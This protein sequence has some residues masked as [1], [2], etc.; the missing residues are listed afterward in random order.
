MASENAFI[1][2]NMVP[3]KLAVLNT[4]TTQGTNLV[5]LRIDGTS[6]GI[7]QNTTATISFTMVPVDPRDQNYKTVWL[8]QGTDGLT[9]PAVG[10]ADGE[11]LVDE[12]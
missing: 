6:G 12:L 9:Y 7:M 11:L 10:T 3:T 4:D 5:R 8:F 1:D 2:G